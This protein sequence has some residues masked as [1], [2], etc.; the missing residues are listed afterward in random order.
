MER[1]GGVR[2]GGQGDGEVE[3]WRA[4]SNGRAIE[5]DRGNKR[6]KGR[7]RRVVLRKE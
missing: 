3:P 6:G 7:R 2:G 1:G 5:R 4:T